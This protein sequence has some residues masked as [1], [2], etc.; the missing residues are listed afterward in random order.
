MTLS[1]LSLVFFLI[2]HL[3]PLSHPLRLVI[4]F[5]DCGSSLLSLHLHSTV[6]PTLEWLTL[7]STANGQIC[8]VV[9]ASYWF[10]FTPKYT[11]LILLLHSNIP[12]FSPLPS[13]QQYQPHYSQ[14]PIPIF[15]AS[16]R[17]LPI[18]SIRP[19]SPQQL[20]FNLLTSSCIWCSITTAMSSSLFLS[21]ALTSITSSWLSSPPRGSKFQLK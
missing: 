20:P 15:S 16:L 17:L 21:C 19:Y 7:P 11:F 12:P 5:I 2:I 1:I 8:D 4:L 10:F 9:R 14:S 6:R 3:S 13:P 18:S